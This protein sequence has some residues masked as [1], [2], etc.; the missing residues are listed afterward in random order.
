MYPRGKKIINGD[1]GESTEKLRHRKSHDL[2]SLLG[3]R[4]VHTV[5]TKYPQHSHLCSCKKLLQVVIYSE[6]LITTT[7]SAVTPA[8]AEASWSKSK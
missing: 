4:T 7:I 2:N 1:R 3:E 5:F 6:V 8:F